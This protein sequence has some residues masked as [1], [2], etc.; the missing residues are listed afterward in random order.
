MAKNNI[1]ITNENKPS[2]QT[3]ADMD[4]AWEDV[5]TTWAQAGTAI[6]KE[7]KNNLSVTNESKNAAITIT[8]E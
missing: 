4:V 7:S 5:S 6:T 1:S 2:A 8:N 3:W